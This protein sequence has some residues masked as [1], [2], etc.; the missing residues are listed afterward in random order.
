MTS[1]Q[2]EK[3]RDHL[4][5]NYRTLLILLVITGHF[6]ETIYENN[7]LLCGL[8]WL[9][10]TFHVPAFVFISGYFSKKASSLTVLLKKLMIP[11]LVFEVLYY[12]LY[13]FVIHKETSLYLLYPKFTLW[14]LVTL[15]IWKWITPYFKK[16]PGYFFIS[17]LLGLAI[18]F[19]PM[20]DNFLTLPRMLV[21]Y[22]YFLAGTELERNTVS[23]MRTKKIG[24]IHLSGI[25]GILFA[26]FVI[27]VFLFAKQIPGTPQVFYGRYS[28]A[29]MDQTPAVGIALRLMA[30]MIGFAITYGLLLLIPEKK[31]HSSIIGQRTLPIY[32]FHGIIY[33]TIEAFGLLDQIQTIPQ[34]IFFLIRIFV[35]AC[36]LAT[37]PFTAFMNLI[38]R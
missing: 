7:W 25:C 21:F 9:I 3:K 14:Y 15:F 32:L 26:I 16:I 30:Y 11:Y 12:L 35:L 4:F 6:I 28:Y 20:K 24:N 34:T 38:S 17:L 23:Q 5:D 36:I 33:K 22:P 29:T 10:Y 1:T 2:T 13:T 8:K 19:S 31:M 18:G 37:R 27:L